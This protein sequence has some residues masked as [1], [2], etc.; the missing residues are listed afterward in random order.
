MHT[1]HYLHQHKQIPFIQMTD[2]IILKT[3]KEVEF[4]NTR[5]YLEIFA[6]E[7]HVYLILSEYKFFDIDCLKKYL[8][9]NDL[10]QFAII[11]IKNL[12]SLIDYFSTLYFKHRDIQISNN[13]YH[14][15]NENNSG[16]NEC[17]G[18]ASM[19]CFLYKND[20]FI[21][22]KEEIFKEK[23]QFELMFT[24]IT[25]DRISTKLNEIRDLFSDFLEPENIDNKKNQQIKVV[26]SDEVIKE[27][28]NDIFKGNAFEVFEVYKENK[29]LC[30]NSRTDLRVIFELLKND[31]LLRNTIELKHY[32]N[33]LN[34]VYYDGDI[35]ELKKQDLNSKPN[36]VRANDYKDYKKATLKQP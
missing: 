16:K 17:S 9:E 1:L 2:N 11:E 5:I 6:K 28:H 3:I 30:V 26:N 29:Q 4:F 13:F 14:Y 10:N 32:I 19:L 36:I 25:A 27:L 33:W 31:N 18:W 8:I 20:K 21:K 35:T 22:T 12:L 34:W 23:H 7:R 15:K 24:C